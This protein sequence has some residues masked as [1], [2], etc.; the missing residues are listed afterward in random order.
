MTTAP[1]YQMD[2]RTFAHLTEWTSANT[3]SWAE[4]DLLRERMATYL[5]SLSLDEAEYSLNHGW[6]HVR[7]LLEG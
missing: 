2:D 6:T 7:N 4:A 1:K 5:E 3:D